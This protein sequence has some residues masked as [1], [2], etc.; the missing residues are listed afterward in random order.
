MTASAGTTATPARVPAATVRAVRLFHRHDQ[1]SFAGCF[2]V[3]TR[4]VIRWEQRGVDLSKLEPKWRAE[5]L[6]WLLGRYESTASR[7]T[8]NQ[9]EVHP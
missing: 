4:T 3:T 6:I 7:D 9:G 1:T 8:R 2:Q 5:L